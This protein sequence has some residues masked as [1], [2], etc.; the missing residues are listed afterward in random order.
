MYIIFRAE[1]MIKTDKSH[2]CFYVDVMNKTKSFK[3]DTSTVNLQQN[4]CKNLICKGYELAGADPGGGGG[5]GHPARAPLKFEKM[6]FWRKI[7]I[8]RNIPKI[9]QKCSRLPPLD[10]IFLSAPPPPPPLI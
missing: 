8:L 2:P 9:S 1:I 5:G 4:Y 7:V 6:I 3:S 10:A